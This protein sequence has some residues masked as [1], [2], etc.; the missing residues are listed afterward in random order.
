MKTLGDFNSLSSSSSSS[1]VAGLLAM[2]ESALSRVSRVRV[3][4]LVRDGG[5][6]RHLVAAVMADPAR[7]LNLLLLLRVLRASAR[8]HRHVARRASRLGGVGTGGRDRRPAMMTV[9]SYVFVGVAPRT[10]GVQHADGVAL[11]TAGTVVWLTRIFGPLPQLLILIGN[12]LTP[13][14]GFREGPFASEAELRDLVD[15]AEEAHRARRAR[16][17]PL[18][19]RARRHDRPRGDGAAHRHR[20]HRARQD[21]AA[22]R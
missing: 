4:E 8:R 17:D 13:G 7:Y 12:A 5:G 15:L 16:D 11:R 10:L 3:E 9:V 22:R 20:V 18:G 21:G 14:K 6:S 19:L 1:S 2:T